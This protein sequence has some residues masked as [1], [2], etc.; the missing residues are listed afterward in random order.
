MSN[1]MNFGTENIPHVRRFSASF[2]KL[3]RRTSCVSNRSSLHGCSCVMQQRL[4]DFH[5][6]A[7][8]TRPTVS[9]LN[10]CSSLFYFRI[11]ALTYGKGGILWKRAR[12]SH[13]PYNPFLLPKCVYRVCMAMCLIL[14]TYAVGVSK[15]PDLNNSE[16][17]LCVAL[18]W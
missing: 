12:F 6:H 11:I 16:S 8:S 5:V 13:I 15:T 4:G 1:A 14:C 10:C 17:C 9:W 2:L 7:E 18:Y 3:L